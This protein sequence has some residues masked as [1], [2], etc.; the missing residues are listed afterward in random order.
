MSLVTTGREL[1]LSLAVVGLSVI[2]ALVVMY[3]V[4][5]A[6][7]KLMAAGL[8]GIVCVI[9]A[10]LLGNPR[11]VC[12]WGLMLTLPFDLSKRFGPTIEKM[13]GESSFRVEM[14]DPFLLG[15][16]VFIAMDI[17]HRERTGPRVPKLVW[18]WVAIMF[19][20]GMAILFGPWRTTAAHEVF[21]M[22]KVLVLFVVIVS[23]LRTRERLMHCVAALVTAMLIQS[24]VGLIQYATRKHLG[25]EL[26]GETGAGTMD[27]LASD[28]VRTEKA[29][30]AG[31]FLNHPNIF[32]AFLACLIPLSIAA[33]M[34]RVNRF[35]KLLFLGGATLGMAALIGSLS[36]SGWV[37]AFGA[38][39][40]LLV[41]L[42]LHRNLQRRAL[43]LGGIAAGALLVVC[44]IFAGPIARRMFES[45]ESAMLSRAEYIS[46]ASGMIR[47]K[48]VFG[49]GLN[50]YVFA[51]PPF[52]KYGARGARLRYENWLPPV[53]NI[54]LL[55]WAETGIVGLALHLGM[56]GMILWFGVRNLRAR[57]DWMFAINAACLAAMFALMIDGMFSF[58]LRINSVLRL[59]WVLSGLIL[60]IH[61]WRMAHE[62]V[63]RRR[64][65]RW[66]E[67]HGPQE[68]HTLPDRLGSD[69]D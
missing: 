49:W 37:S 5:A 31:A 34:V 67:Q 17:W 33:F 13:G 3:L 6:P 16:I 60:A 30:R 19:M 8:G 61:Y 42:M 55:W 24:I 57:D 69:R 9:G 58:T 10:W 15:L 32:G 29:F 18:F 56:W 43:L 47:A 20:G 48:P 28:S 45:K 54:Y 63:V 59:F 46:D 27:Q 66:N 40:L 11:L 2:G 4:V 36:R 14:S 12:L 51:A 41:L 52:T 65:T 7:P 39:L 38:C 50:S 25:L 64:A 44:L 23:E 62:P 26:L 21:R 1:R 53:H 35:Y 22:M 68:M